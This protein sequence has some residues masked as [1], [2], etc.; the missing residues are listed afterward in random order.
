MPPCAASPTPSPSAAELDHE[1]GLTVTLPDA[2]FNV[3]P[4]NT[5]PRLRLNVEAADPAG[6]RAIRDEVLRLLGAAPSPAAPGPPAEGAAPP[7]TS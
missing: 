2:W 1:D 6:M 4:S 5:E 7:A 3:R